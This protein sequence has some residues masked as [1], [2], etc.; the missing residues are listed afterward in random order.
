MLPLQSRPELSGP[1]ILQMLPNHGAM[2]RALLIA[3]HDD[4][5]CAI[6]ALERAAADDLVVRR[7]KKRK[8]QLRDALAA[9]KV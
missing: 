6:A 4:L 9:F 3:E 2:Q 8:L 5:D 1:E 7:M